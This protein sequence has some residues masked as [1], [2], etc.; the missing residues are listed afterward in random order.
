MSYLEHHGIKG[1]KW[2]ERKYQY[3]DGSLTPEGRKRYGVLGS[4][5]AYIKRR[6]KN[7]D[8]FYKESKNLGDDKT[9]DQMTKKERKIYDKADANYIRRQKQAGQKYRKDLKRGLDDK[10]GRV[11]KSTSEG[12]AKQ[13]DRLADKGEYGY[14]GHIFRSGVYQVIGDKAAR[15]AGRALINMAI[16]N[17]PNLS[18]N[19]EEL[20]RTAGRTGRKI[21]LWYARGETV[22]ALYAKKKR[23]Q[24]K[25]AT[26]NQA[27]R[28]YSDSSV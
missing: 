11:K 13:K 23:N 10:V 4:T 8:K 5:K 9:R 1:Q 7:V 3:K 27:Y 19:S 20:L 18:V 12:I 17:N 26:G 21:G 24:V 2:G 28:Y 22:A 14:I 15:A 25:K 16:K 6:Q